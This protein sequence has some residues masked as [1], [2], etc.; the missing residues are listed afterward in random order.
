MFTANKLDFTKNFFSEKNGGCEQFCVPVGAMTAQCSCSVG[1]QVSQYNTSGCNPLAELLLLA[2][3]SRLEALS[4]NISSDGNL[5][6]PT[7]GLGQP[8][9]LAFLARDQ[10]THNININGQASL[11]TVAPQRLKLTVDVD[12]CFPRES[13]GQT[14]VWGRCGV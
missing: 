11:Y 2:V 14:T 13:S 9:A 3:D 6:V 12:V 8:T 10:A 4:P 5:L 1:Y 7:A